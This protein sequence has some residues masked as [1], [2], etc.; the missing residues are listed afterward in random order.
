VTFWHSLAHASMYWDSSLGTL[1]GLNCWKGMAGSQCWIGAVPSVG[2]AFRRIWH[3]SYRY[4]FRGSS[5]YPLL[6][7]IFVQVAPWEFKG[8]WPECNFNFS[9]DGFDSTEEEILKNI[10]S[11]SNH[12]LANGASKTLSR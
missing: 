7:C 12:I 9:F 5:L 10:G 4:V 8:S 11:M 2:F 3:L 6:M 1:K